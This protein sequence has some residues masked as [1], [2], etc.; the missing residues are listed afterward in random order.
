MPEAAFKIFLLA[1]Y[2][3]ANFRF[4][5]RT[6]IPRHST[7]ARDVH[8]VFYGQFF[9]WLAKGPANESFVRYVFLLLT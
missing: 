8:E 1:I 2:V 9:R 6:D 3:P 4:S 5:K 7:A